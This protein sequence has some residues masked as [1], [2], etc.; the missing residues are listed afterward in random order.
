MPRCV[1]SQWSDW[2]PPQWSQSL[3]SVCVSFQHN[4]TL[5]PYLG[6]A[7]PPP[8]FWSE[9]QHAPG[10]MLQQ[11]LHLCIV[12]AM[13]PSSCGWK[14]PLFVQVGQLHALVCVRELLCALVAALG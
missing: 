13:H 8:L 2:V 1:S 10:C 6:K 4:H 11:P 14:D 3:S 7:Y 12:C 9:A 5:H